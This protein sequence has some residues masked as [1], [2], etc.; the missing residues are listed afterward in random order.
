VEGPEAV[1]RAAFADTMRMLTRRIDIFASLP[2]AS[3]DR[4]SLQKRLDAIGAG[5][6]ASG[7]A[8]E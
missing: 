7:R 8:A 2:L 4:L 3:L 5:E 1:K 6:D